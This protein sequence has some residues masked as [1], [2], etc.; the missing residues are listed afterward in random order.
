VSGPSRVSGQLEASGYVT[1]PL[2]PA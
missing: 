1:D 2:E